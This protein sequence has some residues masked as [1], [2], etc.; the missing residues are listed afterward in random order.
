MRNVP[1]GLHP[2]HGWGVRC[3]LLV[4][5]EEAVLIDTGL[6]GEV[7]TVKRLLRRLNLPPA[8]LNVILLT[9]G[10]LDHAANLAALKQWSRARVLAHP[11]EQL[12]LN[13]TYP[14]AGINRW[15]G[16]LEAFGRR[17]LRYRPVTIDEPLEDG[18]R[19]PFWGGLQVIHLPGHTHGHCGFYSERHDLLFCGDLFA[20][21]FWASHRPPA[22]LNSAPELFEAAAERV[23][24][25][26][27]RW[28]VPN[29]Y[30]LLDG[31]LHRR[32]FEKAFPPGSSQTLQQR[33]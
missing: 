27:P 33:T 19:L 7:G 15:C 18:Q 11:A 26:N 32:R 30:D 10:H 17:V 14:Y 31:A 29:H 13:G 23:R 20:S 9:H 25:L 16:K 4:N 24:Q 28:I 8:A 3:H 21:W 22:F 5:G 6:L 1:P 12:Y 2:I